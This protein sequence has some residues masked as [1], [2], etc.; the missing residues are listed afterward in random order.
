M[1][2]KSIIKDSRDHERFVIHIGRQE[3][4]LLLALVARARQHTPKLPETTQLHER[5]RGIARDYKDA[6]KMSEDLR[7]V[8]DEATAP[9]VHYL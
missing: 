4:E 6:L 8:P 7:P 9:P 2:L 5:M 1:K 3:I